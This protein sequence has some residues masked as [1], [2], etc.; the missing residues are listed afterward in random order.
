MA[1]Y[2]LPLLFLVCSSSLHGQSLR[3][4]DI[5]LYGLRKVA[6][7][8]VMA[9][10]E[11][12]R[13][14]EINPE[15]FD[16]APIIERLKKIPGVKNAAVDVLCCDTP[17]ELTFYIG[18]DE[19]NSRLQTHR[20]PPKGKTLLPAGIFQL[21]QRFQEELETGV[22]KGE[23]AEDDSAGYALFRYAPARALQ[24]QLL[25]FAAAHASLLTDVIHHAA[26]AS[27][28]AMAADIIAMSNDRKKIAAELLYA[29]GDPDERVRNNAIRALGVLAAF[30]H[31]RPHE[32]ISIPVEPF[33]SMINSLVWTD[34]NKASLVLMY[35]SKTRKP[36][37]IKAIQSKALHSLAEMAKWKSKSH[38]FFA[39]MTIGHL[40]G[41]DE[42]LLYK[43]FEGDY[44]AEV[45]RMLAS[46]CPASP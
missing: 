31:T 39:F 30:I 44:R 33:T 18:I 46:C 2:L 25:P 3:L 21:Y 12:Q 7:A 24:L 43:K 37:V 19:I 22:R 15:T 35:I 42:D 6:P 29:T 11:V 17:G 41:I 8:S 40:A 5:E 23:S 9:A 14:K 32:T 4:G 27:H 28:R 13:G 16:K 34:K 38:A 1:R 45:D 10:I 36:S 26:D 20:A